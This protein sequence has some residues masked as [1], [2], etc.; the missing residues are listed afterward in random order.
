VV[1]LFPKTLEH[2][3]E[4]VIESQLVKLF[5]V[6]GLPS[7]LGLW[8]LCV[9]IRSSAYSILGLGLVRTLYWQL[10]VICIAYW[11]WE[12][13]IFHAKVWSGYFILRFGVDISY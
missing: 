10:G 2:K 4:A 3:F 13:S 6:L 5:S 8:V 7:L 12:W 1:K 11:G 9:G